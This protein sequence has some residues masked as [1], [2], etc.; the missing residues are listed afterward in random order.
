MISPWLKT[1]ARPVPSGAERRRSAPFGAPRRS[2]R[3][4]ASAAFQAEGCMK[5]ATDRA[6]L[7]IR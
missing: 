2:G 6:R 5:W 1:T 4:C 7:A 3:W